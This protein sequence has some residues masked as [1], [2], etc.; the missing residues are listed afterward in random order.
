MIYCMNAVVACLPYF[1]YK[2]FKHFYFVNYFT[3]HKKKIQS[4]VSSVPVYFI[5]LFILFFFHERKEILLKTV[6][7]NYN[8]I[9]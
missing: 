7:N 8:E 4:S 2:A 3:T 9:L 5:Y 1:V 6:N